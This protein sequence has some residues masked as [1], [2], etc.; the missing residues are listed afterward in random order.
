MAKR[1]QR[2]SRL[3]KKEERRSLRQAIFFGF[4][5]I[6]F[7]LLL[8]FL[9]I[10]ALIKMAIFLGEIR[11]SSQPVKTE[12]VLP[13]APPIISPL[14]EATNSAQIVLRGFAEPGATVEVFLNGSSKAKLVVE[15]NGEFSSSK[16]TLTSGRNEIM[17]Q[18]IDSAGNASQNS[19]KMIIY[20][21][22]SA[23]KLTISEPPDGSDYYG[24][25]NQIKIAGITE[26][27]AAVT[28]NGRLIV[29]NQD[30]SFE[31]TLNLK[32]GGNPIKIV[33]TDQAG[34]QT[35]KEISVNYSP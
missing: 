35:E 2:F 27:G 21:D 6:V 10:P 4:L 34:N 23:P 33:A 16:I 11:S 28:I 9:G 29:I 15:K 30:G 19:A 18:A 8:I 25:E 1:R 3:A 13:P 17:A 31:T 7:L 26:E 20:Y 24:E 12:D 22:L 32:E 14:P 5:T